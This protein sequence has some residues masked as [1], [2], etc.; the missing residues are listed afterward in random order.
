MPKS[1]APRTIPV[2]GS[3]VALVVV[4]ALAVAVSV[5][6]GS[7]QTGVARFKTSVQSSSSA[8]AVTPTSGARIRTNYAALPLAFEANQGQTDPQVKYMARG[9]GYKLF[10]TSSKAIMSLSGHNTHSQ[11]REAMMRKRHGAAGVKAMMKKQAAKDRQA[12]PSA[13]LQM[14]FL[15]ANPHSQLAAEDM[16]SGRVNYFLG[17][18]PSKWHSNVPLYGR[19]NYRKIYPGIDLAFHGESPQLEFDYL[20][21][22]GADAT[23]IA[24]DFQGA[25]S[26]RSDA[27]GNLVLATSAG[28]VQLNKPVAYQSKNGAREFVDAGFVLNAKNQVSFALGPYDHNRELVIDPT[29]TYSTYFG[30][31]S[32]DYGISVA[33]NA[34]G[35]AFVAGATD[36][37]T[38]LGTSTNAS[39]YDAFVT[40]IGPSGTLIFA[41]YFGG[42]LDEFPG[43][44]AV[45]SQGI[46]VSGTTASSD[47]PVTG[48]AAQTVFQG[49]VTGGA[50]DAFAVKMALN[51]SAITWGTYIGGNGSDTG[52]GVAVDSGHNVYV[53]GETFST[54]LGGGVVSPL[55]GGNLLNEFRWGRDKSSTWWQPSQPRDQQYGGR[56]LHREGQCHGRKLWLGQLPGR[57]RRRFGHGRGGE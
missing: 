52:L 53:V 57:Q 55:P 23:A 18:D 49:G 34:S 4:A 13:S 17:N 42:S 38:I 6:A 11:V 31:G 5:G 12:S 22:P 21:S 25:E 29:V 15:G 10:L 46:Y 9:N 28:P 54:N 24:I 40:E 39:G 33:V 30:G 50:N 44:I 3:I 2:A 8:A 19:V 32:A 47:F 41:T 36:S 14:N 16:R 43:G 20:V 48:G 35:D 51:G 1:S 26:V 27:A 45:D 56:R 37:A 7:R